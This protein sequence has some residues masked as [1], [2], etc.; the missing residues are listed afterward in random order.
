LSERKGHLTL[1][2]VALYVAGLLFLGLVVWIILAALG[3][4][5]PPLT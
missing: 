3:K 4:T 2:L 1:N 5:N